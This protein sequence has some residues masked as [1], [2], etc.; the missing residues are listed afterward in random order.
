MRKIVVSIILG[1]VIFSGMR[2]DLLAQ[3]S[4]KVDVWKLDEVVVTGTRTPHLLKD[5]PVET[6]VVTQ[7]EIR[8]SSANVVSDILKEIPGV[9]IQGENFPGASSYQSQMRGLPFDSGYGLILIDGQRVLGGGMGEY[10]VS[11]NQIP[12]SM[13]EKIEVIKGPS[14]VLYGSDA[15]AGVVN[16]IT[17]RIPAKPAFQGEAAYGS[18]N[19]FIA[20][21]GYGQKVGSFGY[22]LNANHEESERGKYGAARDDYR[23]NHVMAKLSYDLFPQSTISFHSFWDEVRWNYEMNRKLRVSPQWENKF[24]DGS[25]LALKGY[26][27]R[28]ETDMFSPGYTR[29]FGDNTYSQGEAQYSRLLGKRHLLTLGSEYL[30]D[31]IDANFA[32]KTRHTWSIY[33]Q[34]EWNI[35]EE[36]TGVLGVRLDDHSEYGTE[37]NPKVSLLYEP[38]AETKF[39]ASVGRAFKSPTIRQLYVF[40]KHG[41]WWNKPNPNLNPEISWGYSLGIERGF[42][43]RVLGS[44]T[45]FRNDI[46]DMVAQVETMETIGG[47]PVRTW[48]NVQEAYTQG[49]EFQ[50]KVH[51]GAGISAIAGY[52]Y[53]DTKNKDLGKRLP[54]CPEHKGTLRVLWDIRPWGLHLNL[55]A[56][57]TGKM[58]KDIQNTGR[59]NEYISADF[60]VTKDLGKFAHLSLEGTNLFN[61]D[62]GEPERDWAGPAFMGR[63][64]L[65][66]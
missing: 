46:E 35:I 15:M 50:L 47:V 53:L 49:A 59:A 66:Y 6:I 38:Q 27:Y 33:G 24:A 29:R 45:F 32:Q 54:F 20:S 39:R 30:E 17:K 5:V 42:S 43:R 65:K 48:S 4:E 34:D 61:S 21:G 14:S 9:Y 44:L 57:Y 19:T 8:H 26:W 60:K 51:F 31:N 22:F 62:Y 64:T 12:L 10:G 7:E 52:T 18:Y 16:I 63:L 58:Y 23:G 28:W 25:N 1:M 55:G 37:F 3:E 11:L 36:L 13:V 56:Q 40:F 41:N 2:S